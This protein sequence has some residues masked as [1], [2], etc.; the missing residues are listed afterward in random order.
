MSP[1]RLGSRS[2]TR[3]GAQPQSEGYEL[4]TLGVARGQPNTHHV[5][6]VSEGVDGDRGRRHRGDDAQ[7]RRRFPMKCPSNPWFL[8]TLGI[9]FF[10]LIAV[11][12]Y[13]L[14]IKL[15]NDVPSYQ[16]EWFSIISQGQDGVNITT[17]MSASQEN[18]TSRQFCG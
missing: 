7:A 3:Q 4:R 9:V 14:I 1:R 13:F 8:R 10:A 16:H 5:E 12:V 2:R 15:Q 11:S 6:N 18:D 17:Q